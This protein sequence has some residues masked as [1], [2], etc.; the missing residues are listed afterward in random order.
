MNWE[1]LRESVSWQQRGG[2]LSR[3]WTAARRMKQINLT[4]PEDIRFPRCLAFSIYLSASSW[5]ICLLYTIYYSPGADE[6][7]KGFWT[8]F[9]RSSC[10][11]PRL[12]YYPD[13][14]GLPPPSPPHQ[15]PRDGCWRLC[16]LPFMLWK[17]LLKRHDVDSSSFLRHSSARL[18][19]SAAACTCLPL[20][21]AFP[22]KGFQ[23]HHF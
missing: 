20:C 18:V 5:Y 22:I 23:D 12:L 2:G 3:I 14:S 11:L 7:F 16:V 8:C 19:V 10:S 17:M 1:L 9:L 6:Y 13:L 21:R 15:P 4:L